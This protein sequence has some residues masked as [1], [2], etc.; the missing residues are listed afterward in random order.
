LFVFFCIEYLLGNYYSLRDVVGTFSL[1]GGVGFVWI[2]RVFL[3]VALFAPILISFFGLSFLKS[4][5]LLALFLFVNEIYVLFF[6]VKAEGVFQ[7]I[8][9]VVFLYSGVYI[10]IFMMGASFAKLDRLEALIFSAYAFFV[11]FCLVLMYFLMSEEFWTQDYKYPP[12]VWYV[13]YALFAVFGFFIFK[14]LF[15]NLKS[16]NP[17]IV[18]IYS[19]SIWIYLWHIWYL[20]VFDGLDYY[21]EWLLVVVFSSFSVYFQIVF[22]KWC[23]CKW[24]AVKLIEPY[25]KG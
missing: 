11:S 9:E 14:I 2:I 7:R 19:N 3:I 20:G 17:V 16:L 23:V 8:F 15:L 6:G 22:L 10:A 1:L 25:F 4:V 13:A 21:F 12:R 18:F 5:A 24:P